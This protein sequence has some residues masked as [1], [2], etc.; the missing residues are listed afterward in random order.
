VIDLIQRVW[1]A[2]L[3]VLTDVVAVDYSDEGLFD[4]S[5]AQITA[6][7]TFYGVLFH[8]NPLQSV[9]F[10]ERPPTCQKLVGRRHDIGS[11]LFVQHPYFLE[12][13]GK[14]AK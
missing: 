7:R 6:K 8:S 11:Q 10:F 2:S 13:F 5:K 9:T 14:P 3:T 12:P 4:A 1:P